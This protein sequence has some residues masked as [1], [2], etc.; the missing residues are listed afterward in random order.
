MK[1]PNSDSGKIYEPPLQV[2]QEFPNRVDTTT[3]FPI[4]AECRVVKSPAELRLLQHVTEVTSFAHA[5]VMRNMKPHMMEYQGESLFRHYCYYN[6][7]CRLV[8]YTPICGCG[9]NASI[10]HY[11]HA[12]EPNARQTREGEM[13]LFDMGAEYFGYGSDVTCSFPI[14]GI[15]SDKQRP[16]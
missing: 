14:N 11:G 15:F 9:P 6:Y 12:G 8:G 3:L 5:Y 2:L 7:G 4:L 1:G 10:L 16:I 13:C